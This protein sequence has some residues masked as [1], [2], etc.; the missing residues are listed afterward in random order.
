VIEQSRCPGASAAS[1]TSVSSRSVSVSATSMRTRWNSS[2]S[3]ATSRS[4]VGSFVRIFANV[5]SAWRGLHPRGPPFHHTAHATARGRGPARARTAAPIPPAA[6]AGTR[7]RRGLVDQIVNDM[8]AGSSASRIAAR[9]S[10][11][12]TMASSSLWVG[13]V[14]GWMPSAGRRMLPAPPYAQRTSAG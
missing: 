13:Q 14:S 3:S 4:S 11:S 5:A 2:V 6:A 8:L 7:R 1:A 9:R 10:G 12:R